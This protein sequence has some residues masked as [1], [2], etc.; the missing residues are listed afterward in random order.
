MPG[1]RTYLSREEFASKY[2]ADP[3]DMEKVAAF[4]H[5]HQLSVTRADQAERV[6][7]VSGTVAALSSAFH[8]ELIRYSSP[9]GNYRGRLGNVHVPAQLAGVVE[10][11]FGLDN[12]RQARP[13]IILP[14]TTARLRD[15]SASAAATRRRRRKTP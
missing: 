3:A 15:R 10:G 11:I 1:A 8:V 5:E 7:V 14:S 6:M 12:R 2:G 9:I 13:H 4:A